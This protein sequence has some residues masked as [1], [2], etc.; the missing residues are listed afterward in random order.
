MPR[1]PMSAEDF[2]STRRRLLQ[3]TAR[4]IAGEGGY[5]GFSMR[6]LGQEVGL[7]AGALYRYFPTR[8]HVLVA[9]WSDALGELTQRIAQICKKQHEPLQDLRAI[10]IAYA[11]FA[12]EDRDRF[13]VLFI[14]NDLGLFSRM[15]DVPALL[16][17]YRLYVE[18]V[19]AAI[20][21]GLLRPLAATDVAHVLWGAVHGVLALPITVED[22]A[23][24]D[25]RK[26]AEIA[27]DAS[28]RGLTLQPKTQDD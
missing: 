6:R 5:S 22:V 27:S 21:A 15:A 25:V 3:A 26:L 28:L 13:R 18:R 9:Y 23:F 14:E 11:D 10:L 19:D 8:Q 2:E 12:L 4:I 20:A 1:P 16:E 7:T 17:G 24:G